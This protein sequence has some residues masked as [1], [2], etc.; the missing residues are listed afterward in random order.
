MSPRL[1]HPGHHDSTGASGGSGRWAA[2]LHST[3]ESPP[4]RANQ[5]GP[6]LNLLIS[7]A[8]WREESAVNQLPRLLSPLGIQSVRADSG[9]EAAEVIRT[10]P[11]HIAVVDLA[12]PIRR[13]CVDSPAGSRILTLLR[14]L[15]QPPP[16]VV[17]R[18]P[19]PAQRESAR[20]L[21]DALR[22]GAFAV[23]D[24]PVDLETMLEVMRRV[25][26]RYYAGHWPSTS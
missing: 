9:E 2:Q 1:H 22:E 3:S 4:I 19:Q 7:Y 15:D 10:Q 20:T 11:V 23:L 17:V 8:G 12:V 14:R 6:R 26:K 25:L 13:D 21:A 24:R 18:P 5:I 16:T